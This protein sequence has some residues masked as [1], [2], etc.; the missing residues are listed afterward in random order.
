MERGAGR[1][2]DTPTA[3]HPKPER[4]GHGGCGNLPCDSA[5]NH[6]S[7]AHRAR[8]RVSLVDRYRPSS[9]AEEEKVAR[10]ISTQLLGEGLCHAGPANRNWCKD[11]HILTLFAAGHQLTNS[12]PTM[13]WRLA[14]LSASVKGLQEQLET[15]ARL[16]RAPRSQRNPLCCSESYSLSL[17]PFSAGRPVGQMLPRRGCRGRDFCVNGTT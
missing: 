16:A 10:V 1:P 12:R 17:V 9:S 14:E 15:Q 8:C 6:W 5:G 4:S 3:A 11:S 7:D 13:E 2:L